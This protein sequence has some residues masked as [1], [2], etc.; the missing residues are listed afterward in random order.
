MPEEG[1]IAAVEGLR[2]YAL[3]A[4]LAASGPAFY[5][6]YPTE[7]R[8]ALAMVR[9]ASDLLVYL[10]EGGHSTIAGRLSGALRNIGRER[11][12]DAIVATMRAADYTV[13]EE[14]PF[15]RTVVLQAREPSPYVNRLRLM[16]V[17]TNTKKPH[18]ERVRFFF[19]RWQEPS[20]SAKVSPTGVGP[21]TEFADGALR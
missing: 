11:M 4:A 3:P 19:V 9:D 6:Q 21:Y 17:A 20:P 14:D 12:A 16:W 13:R 5:R 10:L 7:A 8:A 2:L 15:D 18:P 1:D